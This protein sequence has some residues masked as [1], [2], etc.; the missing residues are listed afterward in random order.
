V[1]YDV[2]LLF[3]DDNWGNIRRLPSARDRNRSGGFGIYYHFDYVGGPRNYKWLNTNPIGRVWEQLHLAHQYGADRIWIVNVGDLKPMEF[4]IEFFLDYAWDPGRWPAD[5]LPEYTRRW[6]AEQF[7]PEHAAEIADILTTSV[8]FAGRRKPELLAPETYSLTNYREA[9]TIVA[10]YGALVDRA[11]RIS[12]ALAPQFRDAFYQ[13]VLHTVTACANLNDLY[14]TVAKNR[15]YAQQGRAATND[16]ADRARTLFERDAAI[17]RYY[18]DSLA[19]GKWS[20]M[21]DQTHIGYTYW[22]EPA[23]NVMP[24]VDVIQVPPAAELGV[25]FEGQI[26]WSPP[27]Q[28]APGGARPRPPLLPVFDAYQRREQRLSVSVDWTR[29]PKGTHRVPVTVTGSDGRR[30]VIQTVV[31]NPISPDRDA[32]VGFVEGNGYVAMEAEHFTRAVNGGGVTW[33]RIPDLGRTLSGMTPIAQVASSVSPGGNGPRLEYRMFLFDSGAVLVKAYLSPTLNFS[34]AAEGLRYAVSFDDETPRI[35]NMA[36][37]SSSRTW[38]QSVA[39]NIAVITT[40]HRLAQPGE[41]TLKFW[42]V[43]PGIVLQRVVVDAGGMRPS[44]LGPPESYRG[45]GGAVR[46]ARTSGPAR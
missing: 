27:G 26:P 9:E 10:E 12:R 39:D 29:V 34:G 7:G 25:A 36:A 19:G 6:A 17:S 4:P 37:D 15:M 21:M 31:S 28:A 32:V 5:R 40:D 33:H 24:R 3:A 23:R 45:V 30:F 16:L 46:E 41:H 43:D 8:K 20:H 44:Y 38:E 14:V 22:Q 42:M 1:P 18:N 11:E 13:L 2:T 35:V